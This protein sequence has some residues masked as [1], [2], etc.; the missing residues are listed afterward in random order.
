MM[1]SER[2]KRTLRFVTVCKLYLD[3]RKKFAHPTIQE[4]ATISKNAGHIPEEPEEGFQIFLPQ[5]NDELFEV[6]DMIIAPV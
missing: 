3:R 4:G 5:K 6:T 1:R 2:E